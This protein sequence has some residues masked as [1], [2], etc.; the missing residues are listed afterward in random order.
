MPELKKNILKFGYAINFKYEGMLAN[1]FDRLYVVTKFI[2][3]TV[4]GLKFLPTDFNERCNYLDDYLVC[5][6]KYMECMS[7]LKVYCRKIVPSRQFYK[8]QISFYNCTAYKILTNEISLLL[9]NFPQSKIEK[10]SIIASL[11]TSFIG[12]A[13][14]GISNCLHNRRHKALHKALVTME[15]NVNIQ[16]NRIIN[17]DDS[18]VM[19][20]IYYSETLEKVINTVHKMHNTMT[21]NEK[22]FAGK[23]DSWGYMVSK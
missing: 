14:E 6:H 16:R 5:N 1:S 12:F 22:L 3:P 10:R 8:E 7:N 23:L 2:L 20:S 18:V 4:N 17:L 13:Y 9:P 21:P 15:I 19:Y 11:I